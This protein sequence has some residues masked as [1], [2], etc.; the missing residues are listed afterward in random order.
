[1]LRHRQHSRNEPP[2][3][4]A[5]RRVN[6]TDRKTEALIA[7]VD[8]LD[9]YAFIHKPAYRRRLNDVLAA[10]SDEEFDRFERI[11]TRRF[12]VN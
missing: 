8:A 2:L 3:W 5:K 7:F 1:M 6:S 10:F 12:T 4:T 9:L 11:Y